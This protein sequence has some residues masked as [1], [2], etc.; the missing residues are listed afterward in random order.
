MN[1]EVLSHDFC[2]LQ[3]SKLYK[4]VQEPF[5]QA[6]KLLS[7]EIWKMSECHF[8][9]AVMLR[10]SRLRTSRASPAQKL[11]GLWVVRSKNFF[12]GYIF[13]LLGHLV[14]RCIFELSARETNLMKKRSVTLYRKKWVLAEMV[15]Q[16]PP[17]KKSSIQFFSVK[18]MWKSQKQPWEGL[19]S[20]VFR[21]DNGW[22]VLFAI[23][24]NIK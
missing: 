9:A 1:V 14:G 19:Q 5:C 17:P 13:C 16:G 10:Q 2:K 21:F 23:M 7:A 15:G 12:K 6:S 22:K 11:Q 20:S 3:P 18:L 4:N 24:G 8:W